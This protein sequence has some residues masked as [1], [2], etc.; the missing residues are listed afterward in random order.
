MI[1]VK[2]LRKHFGETEA[3]RGVNVEIN[4]GDVI[5][6]IGPSGSGKSTFLRCLN[7]LEHPNGGQVIFDGDDLMD[8]HVDLNLHRQKMGISSH[9]ILRFTRS[10]GFLP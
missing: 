5:C 7:L 6:I 2:N 3:L 10:S 9:K 4:Q 8:R 1:S